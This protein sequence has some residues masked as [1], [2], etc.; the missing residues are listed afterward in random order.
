MPEKALMDVIKISS[1]SEHFDHA[2]P[3]LPFTLF[4]PKSPNRV[5]MAK[6]ITAWRAKTWKDNKRDKNGVIKRWCFPFP[7]NCIL[8]MRSFHH[9][10]PS[11]QFCMREFVSIIF[12]LYIMHTKSNSH[13]PSDSFVRAPGDILK[14]KRIF[15]K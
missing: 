13:N 1:N 12:T 14:S 2:F 5:R 15:E 7:N 8:M 9:I 4:N 3:F 6:L 11:F 10:C